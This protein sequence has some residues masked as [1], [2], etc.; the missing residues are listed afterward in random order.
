MNNFILLI[1]YSCF[2]YRRDTRLPETKHTQIT[3][4]K[5]NKITYNKILYNAHTVIIATPTN[6]TTQ[7]KLAHSI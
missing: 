6:I 3:I 2:C 7:E 4:N 5:L 1:D